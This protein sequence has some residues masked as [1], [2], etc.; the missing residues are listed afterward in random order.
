M[1]T[2]IVPRRTDRPESDATG[3]FQYHLRSRRKN[4]SQEEFAEIFGAAEPDLEEV[5]RFASS[6]KMKLMEIHPG[7]RSVVIR[8]AINELQTVFAVRM[9]YYKQAH[10]LC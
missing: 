4:Y 6:H 5:E 9:H 7:K 2:I 1:V 3:L 8:S 10:Q